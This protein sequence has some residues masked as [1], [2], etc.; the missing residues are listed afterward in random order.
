MI[1][2]EIKNIKKKDSH[3]YY[4]QDFTATAIYSILGTEKP[5]KIEFSVEQKPSDEP[6]IQVKMVDKIEY[7]VLKAK[8]DLKTT[9][10]YLLDNRMLP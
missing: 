4:R 8:M 2:S 9:I 1:V 7:P 6:E 10:R 5:G 3:I